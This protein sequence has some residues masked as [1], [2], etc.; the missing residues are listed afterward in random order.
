M[1]PGEGLTLDSFTYSH[2]FQSRN[3]LSSCTNYK[4]QLGIFWPSVRPS[5]VCWGF[6][7]DGSHDWLSVTS[8]VCTDSPPQL[9]RHWN[10]PP[11]SSDKG[12]WMSECSPWA[13]DSSANNISSFLEWYHSTFNRR[14]GWKQIACALIEIEPSRSEIPLPNV[15]ASNYL[16]GFLQ[17][18]Y[19]CDTLAIKQFYWREVLPSFLCLNRWQNWLSEVTRKVSTQQS[20]HKHS[21]VFVMKSREEQIAEYKSLSYALLRLWD[22]LPMQPFL[23]EAQHEKYSSGQLKQYSSNLRLSKNLRN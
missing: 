22:R 4:M 23:L 2:P 19:C 21:M 20:L 15:T 5:Y 11:S 7:P 18:C 16:G 17:S 12:R 9:T 1:E 13:D 8:P 3:I 14:H 6:P 10:L